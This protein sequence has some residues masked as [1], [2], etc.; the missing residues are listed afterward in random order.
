MLL[1]SV[2]HLCVG[3][4]SR[5]FALHY[6]WDDCLGIEISVFKKIVP[7]LDRL[8]DVILLKQFWNTS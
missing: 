2:D 5:E 7:G 6:N 3:I 4:N 8:F 1:K